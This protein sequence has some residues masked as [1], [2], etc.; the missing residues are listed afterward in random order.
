LAKI[1]FELPSVEIVVIQ[2]FV[3]NYHFIKENQTNKDQKVID[4][5]Q[6]ITIIV[7]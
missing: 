2:L 7:E 3:K 6:D 5:L 1:H 4:M